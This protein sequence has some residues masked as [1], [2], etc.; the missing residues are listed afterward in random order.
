MGDNGF[1]VANG[2]AVVDDIGKLAAWRRGRV[3]NV[4]MHEREAGEP[5]KSE[6]LQPIA[7]VVGYAAEHRIRVKSDHDREIVAQTRLRRNSCSILYR[8]IF[9]IQVD[10]RF[11][12]G[13]VSSRWAWP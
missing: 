7:V 12:K 9:V 11:G 13:L 1:A 6:D 5:H 2:L 8:R 3:E 10:R 4:L